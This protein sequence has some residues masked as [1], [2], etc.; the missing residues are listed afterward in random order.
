MSCVLNGQPF[1]GHT[2]KMT[3]KEKPDADPAA[4]PRIVFLRDP[5]ERFLSAYID[6]CIEYKNL[7]PHCEP[8]VVFNDPNN[9]LTEGLVGNK[10]ANFEAYVDAFP[11]KWNMHF[12][13]MSLYCDGLYR[14]IHDYA[15]VGNMDENFYHDL[16]ALGD[17][18]GSTMT[19]ALESIY[20]VSQ[21]V[22]RNVQNLGLETSAPSHVKEYYSPRSI[23]R[24]LQYFSID[25]IKLNLTVPDWAQEMLENDPLIVGR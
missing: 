12:F 17:Q 7:Q 6:K 2:C 22:E 4:V 23:R 19:N 21:K 8:E 25:Y 9:P 16:S 18:F 11:L 13:P 3:V 10:R 24:V 15:F 1:K 20:K 14:N 5:L